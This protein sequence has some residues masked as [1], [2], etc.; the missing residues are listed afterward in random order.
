[1]LGWISRRGGADC[2]RRGCGCTGP[3]ARRVLLG[4]GRGIHRDEPGRLPHGAGKKERR[5][6][7]MTADA[8]VEGRL[9]TGS[10][11]TVVTRPAITATPASSSSC[12]PAG[13]RQKRNNPLPARFR[14][15]SSIPRIP[16]KTLHLR[17][18]LRLRDTS[19]FS[20]P[21]CGFEFCITII[22][23]T[24]RL[25]P[26][27]SAVW[28]GINSFLARNSV[29]PAWRIRRRNCSSRI[30]RRRHQRHRGF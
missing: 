16:A 3:Q 29:S 4:L 2:R 7:A 11:V 9:R 23:S 14:L 10:P 18:T 26:P 24:E 28:P 1:M 19:K 13:L 20:T 5:T 8:K 21:P 6:F 30:V 15:E 12:V 25:R 22:A 17:Y 27:S